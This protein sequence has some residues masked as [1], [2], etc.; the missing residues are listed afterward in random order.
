MVHITVLKYIFNYVFLISFASL[1]LM[2]CSEEDPEPFKAERETLLKAKG[3]N[4]NGN[5]GNGGG[6]GGNTNTYEVDLIAHSGTAE[7]LI[8]SPDSP[9]DAGS[10]LFVSFDHGAI[11]VESDSDG[12][13]S[14]GPS[15]SVDVNAQ[16]IPNVFQ[17]WIRQENATK[18][19]PTY[20]TGPINIPPGEPV[21]DDFVVHLDTL[22]NLWRLK[23]FNGGPFVEVV[24][25]IQ[26]CDLHFHQ[27]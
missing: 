9:G 5:N 14:R 18:F 13:L 20:S 12:T 21:S 19:S 17:F 11:V 16:K 6:N 3:G 26:F 23:N 7:C 25:T 4:G 27:P 15:F 24:A 2:S 22:V 1:L 8:S 10:T